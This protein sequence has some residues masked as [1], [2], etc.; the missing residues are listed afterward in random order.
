LDLESDD[1]LHSFW[2]PK[3][4]GKVDVVPT[5]T[6]HLWFQA[7]R[8]KIDEALPATFYGQ[9]A[10]LCGISHALMRFRVIVMDQDDFDSWVADYGPPA[11]VTPRAQQGQQVFNINCALCH[12]VN[13][14][15]N[16]AVAE[17]RLTQFLSG[18]DIVAVP[19]PNLT[20]LR[21]RMTLGAGITDLS[22][23]NLRAWIKNPERLK[24]GNWMYDKAIMYQDGGD[25]NLSDDDIDAVIEYLMNLR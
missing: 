15:E 11:A 23:E 19:G 2:V 7:D 6:N 13:G 25:A 14:A 24:P 22:V 8:D 4:A 10:E 1:V 3:L 5:R 20:D 9:C 12:T 21:H 17:T 16:E 18:G